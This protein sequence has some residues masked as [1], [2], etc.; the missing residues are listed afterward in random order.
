MVVPAEL[1][2][3]YLSRRIQDLIRLKEALAQND[4]APA[5]KLGHQVKGNAVT[6][7]FP[8]MASIGM[9]LELA[10]RTQDKERLMSV[11]Q[12]MESAISVAQ[13]IFA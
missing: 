5:L 9:E 4:F 3:K 1:K 13:T 8:Q 2:Q 7:E 6:F 12:K 11:V 10:A